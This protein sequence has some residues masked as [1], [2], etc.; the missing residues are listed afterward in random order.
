MAALGALYRGDQLS[1]IIFIVSIF[2]TINIIAVYKN[3]AYSLH[4][5]ILPFFPVLC[6]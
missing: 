3:Y 2:A 4:L 6:L 1:S 5:D